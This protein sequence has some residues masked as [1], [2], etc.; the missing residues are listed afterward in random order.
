MP[1]RWNVARRRQGGASRLR[2]AAIR[3]KERDDKGGGLTGKQL[4]EEVGHVA[5]LD[6]LCAAVVARLRAGMAVDQP[7][8]NKNIEPCTAC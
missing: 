1:I 8:V 5:V 4:A 3:D 2:H 7:V 6:V